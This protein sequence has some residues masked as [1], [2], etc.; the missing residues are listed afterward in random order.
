MLYNAKHLVHDLF[1]LFFFFFFLEYSTD[2]FKYLS[3]QGLWF[4][5]IF[6]IIYNSY[7]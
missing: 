7:N 6:Q 5:H 2:I 1:K 4:Y 3:V